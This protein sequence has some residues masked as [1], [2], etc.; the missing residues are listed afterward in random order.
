[1]SR[2]EPYDDVPPHTEEE[3]HRLRSRV[4]G[5]FRDVVRRTVHSGVNTALQTEE[6]LRSI[7][8]DIRLPREVVGYLLQ[9]IDNTKRELVQIAAREF[10]EFLDSANIGEELA[11]ILT[12]LSFEIRTEVR[13]IPN[14]QALRP[15]VSSRVAIRNRESGETLS[16]EEGAGGL[17]DAIRDAATEFAG[18][19]VHGVGRKAADKSSAAGTTRSTSGAAGGKPEQQTSQRTSPSATARSGAAAGGGAAAASS[20]RQPDG[21]ATQARKPE[22]KDTE[23]PE[24]KTTA[25]SAARKRTT[26]KRSAPKKDAEE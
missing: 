21:K 9:Q 23:A 14:D 26:R 5:L 11:K 18:R 2:D 7:V 22:Q 10:R 24:R 3:Q 12:T 8:G 4:E 13:F 19:F 17:D 25:R 1:M 20:G 6:S 15:N 16:E